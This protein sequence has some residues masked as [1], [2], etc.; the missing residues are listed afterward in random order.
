MRYDTPI[1]FRTYTRGEYDP[2]T[3]NYNADTVK[4]TQA[5]ASVV[6]A[7]ANTLRLIYGDLRQGAVKI[8]LQN[9]RPEAFD[10]IRV[11]AKIYKADFVRLLRH[12]QTIIATEEQR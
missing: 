12:K 10:D 2:N 3:G 7:D 8:T 11:G 4:E 6:S 9:H 5:M 1:F